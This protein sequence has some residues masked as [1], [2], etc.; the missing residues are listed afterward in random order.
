MTHTD[1]HLRLFHAE[2]G[3]PHPHLFASRDLQCRGRSDWFI[4]TLFTMHVTLPPTHTSPYTHRYLSVSLVNASIQDA[5]QQNRQCVHTHT[6][7]TMHQQ[8]EPTHKTLQHSYSRSSNSHLTD[9]DRRGTEQLGFDSAASAF[10]LWQAKSGG[11][12][13]GGG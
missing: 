11:G 10:L 13:R 1:I 7:H 9:E 12:G 5:T 3:E 4:T 6:L 8:T 2:H